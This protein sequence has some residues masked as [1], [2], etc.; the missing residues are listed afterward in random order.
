MNV[1]TIQKIQQ[2]IG[3][4]DLLAVENLQVQEGQRIGLV[5]KNGSGKST[6][7]NILSGR[8]KA[9]VGEFSVNGTIELLP[10]LKK[11]D[12]EKSGGGISQE[13]IVRILAKSPRILLPDEPTTNLDTSHVEW[14]EKQLS[15][16]HGA[17]L[18]VSH[19]RTL[20]YQVC[21]TIWEFEEGEITEYTGNY[22]AYIEQKENERK[23]QQKEYEKYQQKK[24]QLEEAVTEK[25]QQANR[26]I[27][28]PKNLSSSERRDASGVSPYH[29]KL[30]KRLHQN[31]KA[32]QTRLEK[33]EVVEKPQENRSIQMDLP[34]QH[35]FKNKTVLRAEKLKGLIKKNKL[36][37]STTFIVRGGDKV[38]IIGPN[39]SGKT[40]F[41]KKIINDSDDHLYVS[42]AIKIGYFSQNLNVLDLDKIILQNVMEDSK[43]NET[44]VRMSIKKL[45]Y[46]AEASELRLR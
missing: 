9:D 31:R 33:L 17:V 39:G 46:L 36:W 37:N 16:F 35:S 27:K 3:I 28:A 41:L 12:V 22:S 4:R 24:Q 14:V 26:A 23:Y 30:Q 15:T 20:L 40:T 10:Q 18:L 13:Y 32:L 29:Q 34:N 42:P 38:G 5:G 43:Q 25:E 7:F 11:S 19:D 45:E 8:E 21:D 2:S 44:P 1:I 6:L